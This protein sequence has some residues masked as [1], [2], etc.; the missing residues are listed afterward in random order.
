[1]VAGGSRLVVGGNDGALR[2]LATANGTELW[3]F[4]AG[5]PVLLKIAAHKTADGRE[6]L[7]CAGENATVRVLDALDGKPVGLAKLRSAP[8]DIIF[9]N[10]ELETIS[11]DG[12]IER[13]ALPQLF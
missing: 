2:C 8:I 6:L 4:A 7:A 9:V 5:A 12:W 11:R 3:S 13:F 1:M 10:N